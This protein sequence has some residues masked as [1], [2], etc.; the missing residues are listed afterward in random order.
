ARFGW[1]EA[2]LGIAALGV[3]LIFTGALSNGVRR[4][5]PVVALIVLGILCWIAGNGMVSAGLAVGAALFALPAF[6]RPIRPWSLF[7]GFLAVAFVFAL[8]AQAFAP[9]TAFVL[10]WPLLVISAGAC[11]ASFTGGLDRPWA[12]AAC[13]LAAILALGWGLSETHGIA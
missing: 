8:T 10:A 3:T 13:G 2:A 6:G 11:A 9:T 1:Y 12:L 4:L 5:L 7:A